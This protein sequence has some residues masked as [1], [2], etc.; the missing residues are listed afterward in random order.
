MLSETSPSWFFGSWAPGTQALIA[1]C[2]QPS[3]PSRRDLCQQLMAGEP[4]PVPKS[5][6]QGWVPPL[7]FEMSL[8]SV[9]LSRCNYFIHLPM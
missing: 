1:V 6:I 9:F 4:C 8:V 3:P 5:S 2:R 7:L